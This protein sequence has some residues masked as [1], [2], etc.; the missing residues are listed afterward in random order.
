[1]DDVLRSRLA[2]AGVASVE[3]PEAAFEALQ[4]AEGDGA[5]LFDRYAIEA[6]S[7]GVPELDAEARRRAAL[8]FYG[9]QWEGFEVVGSPRDDP[10]EVVD[11]DPAWP[12]RFAEWRDRLAVALGPVAARI[13]HVGST[14][15]P[16][17]AAKPILDIQVSVEDLSDEYAYVPALASLGL[18]LRS[19]DAEHR[20][21]RPVPDRPRE[22]H[23][24]V[25]AVDS[26]WERDH[27]RFRDLLRSDD[28][29]RDAYDDLKRRLV[30]D[31][32]DDRLA[33]TERKTAFITAALLRQ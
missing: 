14:A 23:V 3:D 32:A 12:E 15:V 11:Y 19:R 16:G 21:I 24:H 5:T 28:E 1:M 8:H 31:H 18:E 2:A 17:L 13:E 29:L 26:Q 22:V 7:L 30:I 9:L 10:I 20:Y 6:A 25:C 33:Y 27:L 4:A